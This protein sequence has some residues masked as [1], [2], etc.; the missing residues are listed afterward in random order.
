MARA[1][2]DDFQIHKGTAG[3]T[4]VALTKFIRPD[5]FCRNP[6]VDPTPARRH[7]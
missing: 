3:G 2:M 7:L 6:A 4:T 5:L 1:F